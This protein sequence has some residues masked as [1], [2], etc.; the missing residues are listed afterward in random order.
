MELGGVEAVLLNI[1]DYLDYDKYEVVLLLNYKQGE[2]LNR[3]PKEVNILAVGEGSAEFSSVKWIHFLQKLKRR[4]KYFFFE[5]YPAYFYKKNKL[6]NL[7]YEVAFSH[8]LVEDISKSP[9]KKSKKIFWIHGDFR[10][11]A[12]S[13]KKNQRLVDLLL[14]FDRGIF[15]SEHGKKMIET[16]WHV[17]LKNSIVIFNPF[18]IDKI[19]QRA[20]EK[21]EEIYQDI[22]FVS[23]GR[24]FYQK[25]FKDLLEAHH[26]LIKEGYKIKTLIIGDGIQR[27]EL[28]KLIKNYELENS[29]F[30]CGFSE[31]PVKYIKAASYFILPSY[32]E[33]YP[34]VIGEALCLN[35]PVLSTDVGGIPE[36]I[37]HN[38]NGILFKPGKKNVYSTMK[39]VLDNE[40][41]Q[42]KLSLF[43]SRVEFAEKNKKIYAQLDEL[44]S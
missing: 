40:S 7:D 23:V 25:G 24:L 8:N 44:F 17:N 11:S 33:S 3:I 27:L 21:V 39:A 34:L 1:L 30:L 35:K 32:S 18:K 31:N 22:N 20:E 9:N 29:F 19:L 42:E 28:E 6:L 37:H 10:N 38:I 5:T 13:E 43:D 36:M 26:Q 4:F 15:V 14:K 41:L 12:Y 2:F 16:T